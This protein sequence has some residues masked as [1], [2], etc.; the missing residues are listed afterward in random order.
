MRPSWYQPTDRG[1]ERP[2]GERLARLRWL[3]DKTTPGSGTCPAH[4]WNL[5]PLPRHAPPG[6]IGQEHAKP[7]W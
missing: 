5:H 1:A 7:F 6:T 3:D 4:S 2:M